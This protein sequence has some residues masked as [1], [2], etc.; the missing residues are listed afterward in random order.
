MSQPFY[1]MRNGIKN[2]AWGSRVALNHLFGL[3]NPDDQPQAEVWM[4][5]HPAGCSEIE[6]DTGLRS[7]QDLISQRPAE[8]LGACAGETAGQLPYLL[9]LLSAERALSLQVHPNKLQAE[10]GFARQGNLPGE[11]Y[12]DANHKPELVFALTPFM[13]MN[14]SGRIRRLL[15]TFCAWMP[16]P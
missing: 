13:A 16:R 4:G 8:M 10:D 1:R 3:L 12:T 5:S 14:G 11:D 2:Y 7:L 15:I 9:K 6:T